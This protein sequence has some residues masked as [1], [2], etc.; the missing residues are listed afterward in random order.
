LFYAMQG[1][2][3]GVTPLDPV[4]FAAAPLVLLPGASL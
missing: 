3:F 2:L 1:L 4:A